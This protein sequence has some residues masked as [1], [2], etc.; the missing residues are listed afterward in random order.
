MH[1]SDEFRLASIISGKLRS[2]KLFGVIQWLKKAQFLCSRLALSF[3]FIHILRIFL[4]RFKCDQLISIDI[5]FAVWCYIS[6]TG[7]IQISS[8]IQSTVKRTI[9]YISASMSIVH[10]VKYFL[11]QNCEFEMIERDCDTIAWLKDSYCLLVSKSS[12]FVPNSYWNVFWTHII[13]IN[14]TFK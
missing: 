3:K 9:A 1:L 2:N 10:T 8:F 4:R 11:D 7:M 12:I 14:I 13:V 5:Q 6:T